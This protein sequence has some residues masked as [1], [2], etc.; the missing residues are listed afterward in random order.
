MWL[1]R[2]EAELMLNTAYEADKR[3]AARDLTRCAVHRDTALYLGCPDIDDAYRQLKELGVASQPPS[4]THHGMKQLY[5][6]DPG[7][8]VICLQWP[9]EQ[10]AR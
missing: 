10:D 9:A 3:P 2:G 4:V 8:F 7:G 5:V 1:K 6:S